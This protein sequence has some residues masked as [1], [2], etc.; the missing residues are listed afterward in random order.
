M[1]TELGLT[2]IPVENT[3]ARGSNPLYHAGDFPS[4]CLPFEF[5]PDEFV[6]SKA[7]DRLG[8]CSIKYLMYL[9][10]EEG[11][12]ELSNYPLSLRL[13]EKAR[14]LDK[15]K[16]SKVTNDIFN[17]FFRQIK[18]RV[19]ATCY[20]RQ[21]PLRYTKV[22]LTIPHQWGPSFQKQYYTMISR[23][24]KIQAETICFTEESH[25]LAHYML[26][27][28]TNRMADWT[29]VL[30]LDFGGHSMVISPSLSSC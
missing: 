29:L 21:V 11:Q 19:D 18:E 25:G 30:F 5:F 16:L 1:L 26:S 7:F 27:R 28:A 24:F 12:V 4:D 17:K 23:A 14:S 8:K 15:Q 3:S 22:V 10:A 6:G 13:L 2:W 9:V 20:D